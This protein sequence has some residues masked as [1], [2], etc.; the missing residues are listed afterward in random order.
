M[1][2]ALTNLAIAQ[3][4]LGNHETARDN[5]LSAVRV[6]EVATNSIISPGLINPL[7]GLATSL[8]A[9]TTSVFITLWI[10]GMCL[11]PMPWMLCSP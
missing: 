11:S 6:A 8:I 10:S 9:Q 2:K 3:A 1:A 5:F 7:R 4:S